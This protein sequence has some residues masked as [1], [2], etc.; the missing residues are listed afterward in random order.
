MDLR[1]SYVKR[2]VCLKKNANIDKSKDMVK[3]DCG[4]INSG[5]D[6]DPFHTFT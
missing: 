1:M 6:F 2:Q 5:N 4:C 3:V